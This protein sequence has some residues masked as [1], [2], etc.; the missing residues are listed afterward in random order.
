MT[1][2]PSQMEHIL[3]QTEASVL[4][5]D[6]GSLEKMLSVLPRCSGVKVVIVMGRKV[7][8]A[9]KVST[10]GRTRAQRIKHVTLPLNGDFEAVALNYWFGS[11]DVEI[12]ISD[13]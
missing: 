4:L 3:N 2:D 5:C 6:A 13:Y 1:F 11:S 9:M 8:P 12:V 7:E 10:T